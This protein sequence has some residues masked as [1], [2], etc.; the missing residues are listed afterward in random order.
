MAH[1]M[2]LPYR[3]MRSPVPGCR[4]FQLGQCFV[5][6]GIESGMWHMSISRIDRYPTWDEIKE[7]RYRFVPDN[8]TM[9]MI[10]PPR[11]EYVNLHPNCFHLHQIENDWEVK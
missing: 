10:L 4:A 7:A 1:V 9:A 2:P 6:C 3:E 11:K 5:I 8:V